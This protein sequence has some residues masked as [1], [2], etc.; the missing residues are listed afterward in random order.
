MFLATQ[1]QIL[2]SDGDKKLGGNIMESNIIERQTFQERRKDLMD[3]MRE[4]QQR[5]GMP[6]RHC[7]TQLSDEQ[8]ERDFIELP[9]HWQDPPERKK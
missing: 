4:D 3:A 6:Y 1:A 9:H 8:P 2:H 5:G 7:R